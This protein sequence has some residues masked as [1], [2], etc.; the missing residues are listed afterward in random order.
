VQNIETISTL[1]NQVDPGTETQRNRPNRVV[2]TML[3]S[4]RSVAPCLCCRRPLHY[5]RTRSPPAG[6]RVAAG[7]VEEGPSKD[8]SPPLPRSPPARSSLALPPMQSS[9]ARTLAQV[10]V[11][12]L[13]HDQSPR[14]TMTSVEKFVIVVWT[15]LGPLPRWV[16]GPTTR[17][18]P[19]TTR[20]VPHGT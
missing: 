17:W 2:E 15:Y 3:V 10:R 5:L 20:L 14:A 8:A 4:I 12:T 16:S 19:G 6:A 11:R 1:G 13:V 18:A 7:E 9:H